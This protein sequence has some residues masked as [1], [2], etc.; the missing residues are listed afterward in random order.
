MDYPGSQSR[1]RSR[2]S[3]PPP[4]VASYHQEPLLGQGNALRYHVSPRGHVELLDTVPVKA[5]STYQPP[6]FVEHLNRLG[7][8]N[9]PSTDDVCFPFMASGADNEN[10]AI[11]LAI[12]LFSH[13]C[14]CCQ[15]VRTQEIG[16]TEQCGRF[17]QMLSPGFYCMLWPIN[18][19]SG[20]LTL[21]IQ[22]LDVT[23]ETKC[24]DNVFVHVTTVIL[25]RVNVL[26]SYNA[27]YRLVDPRIQIQA[28][29]LD[30]V[31]SAI[32]SSMTMDQLFASKRE[33]ANQVLVRLQQDML[34]YGYEITDVLV[35]DIRP[36][37]RVQASM[38][39]I[40]ASRRLKEAAAHKAVAHKVA[41]VCQAQAQAESDH[42]QGVGTA[43]QRR[44]IVRGMQECVHVWTEMDV[45]IPAPPDPKQVMDVL[46]VTQYL[47]TLAAV[48]SNNKL[49]V[50]HGPS[51]GLQQAALS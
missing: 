21:R 49:F 1:R 3:R 48:G 2:R 18:S 20:R 12:P 7:V 45:R 28:S 42:L 26:Q 4:L 46:L 16:F 10:P 38:N 50:H 25:Y 5:R 9:D 11:D 6:T 8:R 32:P 34:A 23:C 47:D 19:I 30:V 15:C 51:E 39:E 17:T 37:A 33:I 40:H 31:R 27:Y 43:R 44:A 41:T 29:V 24:T 35:T 22:Q 14:C 13:G 36:N